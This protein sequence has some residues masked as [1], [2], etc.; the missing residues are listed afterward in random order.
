MLIP[1]ILMPKTLGLDMFLQIITA[2]L[3]KRFCTS[4]NHWGADEPMRRPYVARIDTNG[5]KTNYRYLKMV[6][7]TV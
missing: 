7:A 6:L 5:R 4:K 3:K 1:M 2:K